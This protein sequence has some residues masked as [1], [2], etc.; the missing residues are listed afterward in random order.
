MTVGQRVAVNAAI[1]SAS[2]AAAGVGAGLAQIAVA[3]FVV[4]S[5]I[6]AGMIVAIGKAFGKG[7][8]Q[9]KA[10]ALASAGIAT[11][12][13]KA[14]AAVLAGKVAISHIPVV[15]NV[16]NAAVAFTLT[17]MVGWE[18]ALQFDHGG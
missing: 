18:A 15:G 7:I 14:A 9:S 6:Q 11:T 1:H 17:E 13:G 8:S 12:L 10:Q 3:D 2:A 4:L 5:G 16:T